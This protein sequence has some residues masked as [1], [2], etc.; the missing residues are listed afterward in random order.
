MTLKAMWGSSK[1]SNFIV[2]FVGNKVRSK[3]GRLRMGKCG[4]SSRLQEREGVLKQF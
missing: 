3:A 2:D 4:Y 1:V